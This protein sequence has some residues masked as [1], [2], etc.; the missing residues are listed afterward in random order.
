MSNMLRKGKRIAARKNKK[1][2]K[3]HTKEF[4]KILGEL[5]E[6]AE[7][8]LDNEEVMEKLTDENLVELASEFTD[9]KIE[10]LEKFVLKGKLGLYESIQEDI[11]KATD[12]TRKED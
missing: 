12:G 6:V 5:D 11:E 3:K 2:T 9:L 10:G 4:Y 8:M 1:E 7:A